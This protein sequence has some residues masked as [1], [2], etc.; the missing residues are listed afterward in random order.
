LDLESNK[1]EGEKTIILII[2]RKKSP[3]Q[4]QKCNS[5][6]LKGYMLLLILRLSD[7]VGRKPTLAITCVYT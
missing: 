7:S 2:Q 6:R 1:K 3:I 5:E 4:W